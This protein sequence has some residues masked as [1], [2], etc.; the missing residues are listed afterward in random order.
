MK[1]GL[2]SPKIHRR[3]RTVKDDLAHVAGKYRQR[4]C[5]VSTVCFLRL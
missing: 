5:H 3:T 2:Q 1:A 4:S